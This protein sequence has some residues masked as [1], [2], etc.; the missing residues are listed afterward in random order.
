MD[1]QKA[2]AFAGRMMGLLNES[3]LS[4]LVSI[5][6]RTR[7]FDAMDGRPAASSADIARTA[8]LNDRYVREWLGGMVVGRIVEYDPAAS[9]YRL[10]AE[11]SAFLTRAAGQN[12][13]ACFAQYVALVANVEPDVVDC[14]KR[15][16]GVPYSKFPEFQS[17]QG[18][19]SAALYDAQLVSTILPFVP[20][21]AA[22]L[23]DGIDVADVGCGAGHA[24]N[25]MAK[26]FPKS[27]FTG[28]DFA[29]DG[30]AAGRDEAKRMDL[31]NARFEVC[32]VAKNVAGSY[33][34]IT[35]FDTVHDQ[36]WPRRLLANIARA[37]RPGGALLMMDI[38]ASS[39]LE[40]NVAHPLGPLLYSASV[41]HCMT[42]SLAQGGEGLGTVWGEQKAQE[43]L[44]E[45]G[46]KG[47]AVRH[48][49]GDPMHAFFV[50]TR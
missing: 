12:N 8:G 40:E 38:A 3:F 42:V 4:V 10:P 7:L 20:G 48:I 41:L 29:G 21:I 24:V 36:A 11:H 2:E 1:Q 30:V 28:M 26:A 16:G 5:G 9:T 17:L 22:R 33:D 18:E 31:T 45:A 37:L 43:L 25:V 49:E 27:R 13:M 23:A 44:R 19:E 47:I 15:G 32:D 14:F 39:R 34:L 35:A 46:F 6:H 50:A